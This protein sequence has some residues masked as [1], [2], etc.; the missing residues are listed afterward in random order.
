MAPFRSKQHMYFL[1]QV[2]M[3]YV[4]IVCIY[5]WPK[6]SRSRNRISLITFGQ[7]HHTY[8]RYSLSY[9]FSNLLLYKSNPLK[10]GI[11]ATWHIL[12]AGAGREVHE[13]YFG[14]SSREPTTVLR[15]GISVY[16]RTVVL[17]RSPKLPAT[18]YQ[19]IGTWTD[20]MVIN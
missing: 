19:R 7:S 11:C 6:T 14:N 12:Y 2:Q 20:G 3:R 1:V 16:N 17:H 13:R 15:T 9:S 8:G 4:C 5:V 10:T 18:E